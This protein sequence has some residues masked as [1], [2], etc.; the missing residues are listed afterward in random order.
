MVRVRSEGG[1]RGLKAGQFGGGGVPFGAAL[2][3]LECFL[4]GA[5][6]WARGVPER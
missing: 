2:E 1:T 4:G 5:M 6:E 3:G